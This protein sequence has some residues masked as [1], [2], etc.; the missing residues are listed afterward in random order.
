MDRLDRN[1]I[2]PSGRFLWEMFGRQAKAS[3]CL[4]VWFLK[5]ERE[6]CTCWNFKMTEMRVKIEGV[7]PQTSKWNIFFTYKALTCIR[8]SS[9]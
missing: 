3:G 6:L 1:F 7:K 5:F 9:L 2:K 8:F 4:C